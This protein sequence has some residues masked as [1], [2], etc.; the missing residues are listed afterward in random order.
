MF[1]RKG[2]EIP[3][4]KA[5]D[6][7]GRDDLGALPLLSISEQNWLIREGV[8]RPTS[9]LRCSPPADIHK[10]AYMEKTKLTAPQKLATGARQRYI[11]IK[12]NASQV[13]SPSQLALKFDELNKFAFP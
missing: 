1:H 2:R 9:S 3:R 7:A 6:R 12:S 13:F 5:R 4:Y 11:L 8:K 10:T